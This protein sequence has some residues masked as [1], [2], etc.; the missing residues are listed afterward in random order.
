[1]LSNKGAGVT[2]LVLCFF[3]VVICIIF[4]FI[5]LNGK[6]F[7]LK[8]SSNGYESELVN[9]TSKYVNDYYRDLKDGESLI[10]KLDTLKKLE[11]VDLKSCH[12]YSIVNKGKKLAI[13]AYLRCDDYESKGYDINNE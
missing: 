13:E 6:S 11:Y 3:I 2:G 7:S 1:M 9:A 10:I 8:K 12:G 4:G 5:I